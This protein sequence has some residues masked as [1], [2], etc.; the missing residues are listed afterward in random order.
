MWNSMFKVSS[1]AKTNIGQSGCRKNL[2][3]NVK[4][5]KLLAFKNCSN[6]NI[7]NKITK[8]FIFFI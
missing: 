1:C 4:T 2:Q 8:K 3:N 5:K 7:E 6:L